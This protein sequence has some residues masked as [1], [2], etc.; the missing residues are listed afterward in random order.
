MNTYTVTFYR[1]LDGQ[2]DLDVRAVQV[3]SDIPFSDLDQGDEDSLG[4]VLTEARRENALGDEWEAS[5][6]ANAHGDVVPVP[7]DM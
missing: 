7:D 1:E 3:D 2:D 5:H 4:L 6:I